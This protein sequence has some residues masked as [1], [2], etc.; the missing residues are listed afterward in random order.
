MFTSSSLLT[1]ILAALTLTST[2][3][4]T[5]SP[6]SGAFTPNPTHLEFTT[7][8]DGPAHLSP[9]SNSTNPQARTTRFECWQLSNAFQTSPQAGTSGSVQLSLGDLSNG[10]Y[11]HF[12]KSSPGT[13]HNAPFPQ[14]VFLLSG[15][16]TIRLPNDTRTVKMG[17]GEGSIAADLGGTGHLTDWEAGTSVLQVPFGGGKV[18]AHKVL[19]QGSCR[20]EDNLQYSHK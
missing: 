8:L 1:T 18:P 3:S 16:L 12:S 11:T 20:T 10:T 13:P 6:L 7:L 9:T 19:H 14:Y 15:S 2:T 17:A 5:P 4:C